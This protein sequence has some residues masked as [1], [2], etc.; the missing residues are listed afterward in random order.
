MDVKNN[1]GKITEPAFP[2][3]AVLSNDNRRIFTLKGEHRRSWTA[4]N[5][6]SHVGIC[7]KIDGGLIKSTKQNKCDGGL[8]LD[9]NRSFLV[10][11]K[12]KDYEHAVEQLKATKRYFEDNYSEYEFKFFARIVGKSFPKTSTT[13]QTAIRVLEKSFGKNYKIFENQGKETI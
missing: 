11:F 13:R 7:L 9:D 8:L 6:G 4:E 1:G 3:D 2:T 10:E 12:G 5:P